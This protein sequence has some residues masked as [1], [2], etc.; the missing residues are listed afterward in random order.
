MEH[1]CYHSAFLSTTN[2]TWSVLGLFMA[3]FGKKPMVN[4]QSFDLLAYGMSMSRVH[5]NAISSF[6]MKVS[7]HKIKLWTQFWLSYSISW[8]FQSSCNLV[9]EYLV[10]YKIKCAET[11]FGFEHTVYKL[12]N[13][14]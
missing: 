2:P 10:H 8:C 3:L 7:L 4:C 5:Q 1:W 11:K 13:I 14:A 6:G 9:Q 12:T